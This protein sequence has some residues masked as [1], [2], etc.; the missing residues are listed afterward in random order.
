MKVRQDFQQVNIPHVCHFCKISNAFFPTRGLE[1]YYTLGQ[2]KVR[3]A[4]GQG[5]SARKYVVICAPRPRNLRFAENLVTYITNRN[6]PSNISLDF[7]L[8]SNAQFFTKMNN[9]ANKM[10]IFSSTMQMIT[11]FD[12]PAT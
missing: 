11:R 10:Y 3:P 12:G 9:V 5:P 4:Q 8:I 6:V 1:T 7:L 2:P